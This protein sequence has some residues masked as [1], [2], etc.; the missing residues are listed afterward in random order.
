LSP[1]EIARSG[2]DSRLSGLLQVR[3]WLI[4]LLISQA[5]LFA[6]LV[7]VVSWSSL[8]TSDRVLL[9]IGGACVVAGWMVG[10]SVVGQWLILA[11]PLSLVTA[12]A[13]SSTPPSGPA[14]IALG[15]SVGHVTYA[16]V[17]LLPVRFAPMAIPLGCATLVILWS[18]R[19]SNVVPGALLVAGG[20][21]SVVS[22][23][24]SASALWFVWRALLRRTK[25]E[26]EQMQQ[27]AAR[28]RKELAIQEHSRTWRETTIAIHE[29]LLSTLR[30]ILQTDTIDRPALTSLIHDKETAGAHHTGSDLA[31]DVRR[32]TAARLAAGM[33]DVDASALTLRLTDEVR[34]ATRAAIVECALNATLHGHASRVFVSAQQVGDR[35]IVRISDNGSGVPD[36]AV[37]GIGWSTTLDDGL[38]SVGGTWSIAREDDHTVVRLDVPCLPQASGPAFTD[39]GFQ[40][41]RVL[42]SAPLIAI[43]VVGFAFTVI[44]AVT[45]A[46]G[47]L[48][49]G[50]AGLASLG[51]FMMLIRGKQPRLVTSSVVLGGLAAVPWLMALG[52]PSLGV[53]PALSAGLT[54]A[55]YSLIAVGMWSRWWQW[56][57]GM[58][59]WAGGVLAV[60]SLYGGDNQFP[61]VIALV[62]VLIIVPVVI[63]VSAI[64]TRRY[65]RAKEADALERD[66]M[67]R[68]AIRA[69]SALAIDRHLSVCVAQAEDIIDQLA[70]GADFDDEARKQVACLE[71]L[72]RATIQVDPLSS[73]EFAL[74]A[75]SLVNSA[76]SEC[77]PVRVGTLLSSQDTAPLSDDVK[78][79]LR[80]AILSQQSITLRTLTDGINDYLSL[81]FTDTGSPVSAPL[82]ALRELQNLDVD[83]DVS[84]H[85]GDNTIMTV[86]RPILATRSF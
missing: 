19:P 11:A 45:S 62:N 48:L 77:I 50:I 21:I 67:R 78:N 81:E 33:L 3:R 58:I 24:V 34:M 31:E 57:L 75:A 56:M 60:T 13:L 82:E 44:T 49:I 54:T 15:V 25:A 84:R 30:Y 80:D 43:G 17:L 74:V 55:G 79:A 76:F 10:R 68:E 1:E 65:Q 38:A 20:W 36:D 12:A 39:D 8:P 29:Q 22:L 35:Y 47:W 86:S 72:I 9:T 70:H 26:D 85:H 4:R 7:G 71:G 69:N 46:G 40:Q 63:I 59:A 61:F 51:A 16:L 53:A 28:V 5:W 27:L 14:W 66:T 64:G 32:A 41:G 52:R 42:M 18:W 2:D 83:I 73:G 6:A 37:S 23:A